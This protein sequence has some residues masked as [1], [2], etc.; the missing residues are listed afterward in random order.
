VHSY[1]FTRYYEPRLPALSAKEREDFPP[2]THPLVRLH[3]DGRR[4]LYISGNVA[5]YVGGM[6]LDEGKALH[7]Y[8]IDWVTQPQF[9]YMHKWTIGDVVMWDNRP[10]L[11]KVQ[12]YDPKYRRVLQRTELKGTEIPVG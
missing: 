7:K 2:A 11:H 10:T 5:Y 3:E 1:E 6:A 8:L 4:S 9:V 12:S